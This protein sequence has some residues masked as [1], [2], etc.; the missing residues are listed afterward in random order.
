M[1]GQHAGEI[2]ELDG[3]AVGIRFDGTEGVHRWY[4]PAEL[5]PE[6]HNGMNKMGEEEREARAALMDDEMSEEEVAAHRAALEALMAG[7]PGSVPSSDPAAKYRDTGR[8][9]AQ[10][11]YPPEQRT[12]DGTPVE[13]DERSLR[14]S[15]R[16]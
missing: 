1:P 11:E 15:N 7:K 13:E 8:R 16:R 5:E 4:T 2:A 14:I 3:N 12:N 6:M 10:G 9:G